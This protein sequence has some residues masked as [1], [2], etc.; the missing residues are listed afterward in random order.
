MS[1]LL[2][3]LANYIVENEPSVD[4]EEAQELVCNMGEE[5]MATLINEFQA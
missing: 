4:F 5:L 2:I 3:D 1:D